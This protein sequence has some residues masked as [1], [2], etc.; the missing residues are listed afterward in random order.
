MVDCRP[1]QVHFNQVSLAIIRT[2]TVKKT[3]SLFV[4]Q[5]FIYFIGIDT[6][7]MAAGGQFC[8]H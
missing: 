8:W 4:L 6:C 2:K 7:K 5:E 1:A 3:A